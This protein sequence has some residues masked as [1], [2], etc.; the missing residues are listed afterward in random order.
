[1]A[2]SLGA[3]DVANSMAPSVGARAI[4]VRQA[5][6]I[7][8]GLNFLGAVFFGSE[9]TDTICRGIVPPEAIGDS[10]LLAMGMFAALVSAGLWVLLATFT[11]LPV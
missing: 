8:A 2:F 3:N 11:G 7:A 5:V 9:V 4:T 6:F 1:M 10:N